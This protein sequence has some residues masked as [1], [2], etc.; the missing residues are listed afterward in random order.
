M[1]HCLAGEP[2]K[3]IPAS[4]VRGACGSTQPPPSWQ[5]FSGNSWSFH[6]GIFATPWFTYVLY[7]YSIFIL[8][9]LTQK[10]QAHTWEVHVAQPSSLPLSLKIPQI[11]SWYFALGFQCY[12]PGYF[13][14]KI[15]FHLCRLLVAWPNLPP[16]SG[17][18]VV[19]LI[20]KNF[21][22]AYSHRPSVRQALLSQ[23]NHQRKS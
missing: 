5:D 12:F 7:I 10:I 1:H 15:W 3:K 21:V 22:L 23:T 14:G 6:S 4:P 20:W 8:V 17:F 13:T 2:T 16:V 11:I 19:I 18:S 9:R